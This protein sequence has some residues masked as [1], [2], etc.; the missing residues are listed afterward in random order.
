[1]R[2]A[3]A[4]GMELIT[5]GKTRDPDDPMK[6]TVV[7]QA[8]RLIFVQIETIFSPS[9]DGDASGKNIVIVDDMVQTG[10]AIRCSCLGCVC[11]LTAALSL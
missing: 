3:I 9:Q 11:A 8:L 10:K 6:R 5:C 2:N 7:I 4:A 1:M